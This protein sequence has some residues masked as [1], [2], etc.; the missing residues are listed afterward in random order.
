MMK[1]G[2]DTDKKNESKVGRNR[3]VSFSG[4]TKGFVK[5]R[6]TSFAESFAGSKEIVKK[7]AGSVTKAAIDAKDTARKKADSIIEKTTP[8]VGKALEAG[9][10]GFEQ[11]KKAF[12]Q[13]ADSARNLLQ[14][15]TA[16]TQQSQQVEEHK[17][18]S[19]PAQ[20]SQ[21]A[22]EE[23]RQGIINYINGYIAEYNDT[24]FRNTEL[25]AV[26]S[27]HKFK[28]SVPSEYL[29]PLQ[30]AD[31]EEIERQI[32]KEH[33]TFSK[34]NQQL[35][36]LVLVNLRVAAGP[37]LFEAATATEEDDS[38]DWFDEQPFQANQAKKTSAK[39]Q[40]PKNRDSSR[41]S[42]TTDSKRYSSA[43]LSGLHANRDSGMFGFARVSDRT[44]KKMLDEI[45]QTFNEFFKASESSSPNP[46]RPTSLKRKPSSHS[47]D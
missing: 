8:Y 22:I 7:R 26:R 1:K 18:S 40:S 24:L 2:D 39:I 15:K 11:G 47:E 4:K 6:S 21:K 27:A 42:I 30:P 32:N 28:A 5:E 19:M 43:L 38:H 25:E 44:E 23:R 20:Y 33:N 9:K 13:G 31:L 45:G 12:Q 36:A 29:Q 16:A 41:L 17:E 35:F 37:K 34:F 14:Q 3:S 46:S 10:Q